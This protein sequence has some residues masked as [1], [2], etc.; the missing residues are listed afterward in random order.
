MTRRE[1]KLHRGKEGVQDKRTERKVNWKTASRQRKA[2][3]KGNQRE[4]VKGLVERKILERE[5]IRRKKSEKARGI[6]NRL[7][8]GGQ[9]REK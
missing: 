9:Q 8:R 3:G 7:K 1:V 4:Q 6:G 5:V 2:K